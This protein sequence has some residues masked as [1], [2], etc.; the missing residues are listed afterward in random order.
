V[1]KLVQKW[2]VLNQTT[3]FSDS[4]QST[5]LYMGINEDNK[6]QLAHNSS[7]TAVYID[8]HMHKPQLPR[9]TTTLCK[10]SFVT[11]EQQV[12]VYM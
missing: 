1:H 12:K 2:N 10:Q 6:T 9:D 11:G 8:S 4:T 5:N 3:Y 7:I